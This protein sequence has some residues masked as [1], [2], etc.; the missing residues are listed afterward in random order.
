MNINKKGLKAGMFVGFIFSLMGLI[1]AVLGIKF[2]SDNLKFIETSEKTSG[3]VI[4]LIEKKSDDGYT[5]APKITFLDKADSREITFISQT[6]SNP[7]A[8]KVGENL[9]IIYD[10]NN[11]EK[12]KIDSF[13]NLWLGEILFSAIGLIFFIIGIFVL[14]S[15]IKRKRDVEWLMQNG[16]KIMAKVSSVSQS[17]TR[18]RRGS[19]YLKYYINAQWLNPADNTMHIFESDFLDFDP[20]LFVINKDIEVIIDQ[21]NPKRYFIDLSFLPQVK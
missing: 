19:S 2:V 5:Y 7:P 6:S 12:A 18:S 15:A 21:N 17:L 13:F 8:Y 9:N 16:T 4:E 11:P 10:P 3:T 14:V 1:F 20:S